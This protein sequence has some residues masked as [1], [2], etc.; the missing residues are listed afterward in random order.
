M[1]RKQ[2]LELARRMSEECADEGALSDDDVYQDLA[3]RAVTI[4]Y[5]K[6]MVLYIANDMV[7]SKDIADFAE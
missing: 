5:L 3:Y 2:A 6:A 1:T 4:A 7:W